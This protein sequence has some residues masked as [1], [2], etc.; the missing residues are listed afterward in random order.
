MF[1][2]ILWQGA[3]ATVVFLLVTGI[4]ISLETQYRQSEPKEG[5]YE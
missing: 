3:L 4:W 5:G 2:T 1:W